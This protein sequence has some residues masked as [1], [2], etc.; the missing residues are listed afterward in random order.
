MSSQPQN[1]THAEVAINIIMQ[2]ATK[3]EAPVLEQSLNL[4][5]DNDYGHVPH[6]IRGL[7]LKLTLKVRDLPMPQNAALR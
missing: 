2:H 1:Y 4:R 5:S 7:G 6:I 3:T